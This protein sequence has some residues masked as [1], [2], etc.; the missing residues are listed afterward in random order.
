MSA[1]IDRIEVGPWPMNSYII[2]C[3]VTGES[4]IV[5]PGA[6]HVVLI[7]KLKLTNLQHILIT[8]GHNDHIGA[9]EH[10]KSYKNVPV[11]IHPADAKKFDLRNDFPLIDGSSIKIGEVNIKIIHTPG[12]T[13]GM[14]SFFLSGERVLVG[15]TI[16]IGGPGKTWSPDEFRITIETLMNIVFKWP[17]NTEFYPGHGSSGVIGIEKIK[18]KKFLQK[19]YPENLFGDITWE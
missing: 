11:W 13:P 15:D 16:F 4:V 5:D 17:N 12:H 7:D 18:F 6:D 14:C 3:K 10:I 1:T 19:G 2:T 9:I 8:H